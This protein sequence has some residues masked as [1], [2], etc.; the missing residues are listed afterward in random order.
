M[1]KLEL[2]VKNY[3][4][5][6]II[7]KSIIIATVFSYILSFVLTYFRMVNYPYI[8][9]II[10]MIG[11]LYLMWSIIYFILYGR[12]TTPKVTKSIYIALLIFAL[13]AYSIGFVSAISLELFSFTYYLTPFFSFD[14]VKYGLILSIPV[15]IVLYRYW[16]GIKPFLLSILT[17]I[18]LVIAGFFGSLTS[19][20][21]N[22][23]QFIKD[24][25][26]YGN[27]YLV[28]AGFLD[29]YL[30]IRNPSSGKFDSDTTVA[31][32]SGRLR[33]ESNQ[34]YTYDKISFVRYTYTSSIDKSTIEVPKEK[35]DK[36]FECLNQK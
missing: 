33:P 34:L 16:L 7:H 6:N 3:F 29:S 36:I 27:I 28:D 8:L 20:F 32:S 18:I 17:L 14:A 12:D 21:G 25:P 2:K 31:V 5:Q 13:L 24:C 4:N 26:N 11:T 22:Y 10:S 30:T 9:G 35:V 23:T 15:V 1:K 19:F